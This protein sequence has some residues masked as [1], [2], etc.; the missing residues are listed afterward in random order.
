MPMHWRDWDGQ[1]AQQDGHLED[2]SKG[3]IFPERFLL[4]EG[5]DLDSK[6]QQLHAP[7]LIWMKVGHIQ[8]R[9]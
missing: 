2:E 3:V 6:T 4:E 7:L 9:G 5:E 1:L 8:V